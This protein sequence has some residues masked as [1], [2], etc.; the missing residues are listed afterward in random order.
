MKKILTLFFLAIASHLMSDITWS[1]PLTLSNPSNVASNVEL[2]MDTSGNA[3]AIWLENGLLMSASQPVG[4]SWGTATALTASTVTNASIG[5]DGSGNVTALWLEGGVV[6]TAALPFGGTW[7]SATTISQSGASSPALAVDSTGNAVAVWARGGFI[8][9]STQLVGGSWGVVNM[10]SSGGSEDVPQVAISANGTVVAVWHSAASGLNAPYYSLKQISVG[11]WQTAAVITITSAAIHH[12][13]PHVAIDSNGNAAAIWFRYKV[14]GSVYSN[15]QVLAATLAS[16]ASAWATPSILSGLGRVNPANLISQ[17]TYDQTGNLLAL[18][19]SSYDGDTYN[20][21]SGV[22]QVGSPWALGGELVLQNLYGLSGQV[23]TCSSGDTVVAYMYF[24]GTNLSIQ[25]SETNISSQRTNFWTIPFTP[26]TDPNNGFPVAASTLAGSTVNAACAWVS[27]SGGNNIIQVITGN[28]TVLA[29]PTS[30]SVTQSS[31]DFD[32][33]TEYYN[34]ISWTASTSPDI[35]L[36]NLYRNG[37]YFQTVLASTTSFIDHNA[38]Q[39]G[40]VVY[41]VAAVD[42]SQDQSAIATVSFP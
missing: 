16:G 23:A 30:L 6:E 22:L 13:Y 3:T 33:F 32:I 27:N 19:T 12:D 11:T 8:E 42:T 9:S 29:P 26:S 7:S 5:V 17:L 25:T 38:V 18:W 37:T 28:K 2:V 40:S 35:F 36:Y 4:G 20:V 21:E 14:S 31:N 1:S 24:D 15:V 10:L 39:G 41:G 34:T